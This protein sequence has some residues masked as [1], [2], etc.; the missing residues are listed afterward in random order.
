MSQTTTKIPLAAAA[1][2][3]EFILQ[4]LSEALEDGIV[5]GSIRRCRPEVGDIELVLLPTPD[6]PIVNLFGEEIEDS[7]ACTLLDR[8][9]GWLVQMEILRFE[10]GQG[11]RERRFT[12]G[13]AVGEYVPAGNITGARVTLYLADKLNYGN[14]VVLR[15]GCSAF[16]RAAIAVNVSQGG[17]L[18]D[19]MIHDGGYLRWARS[20]DLIVPCRTESEFLERIHV[21]WIDPAQRTEERTDELR[22]ALRVGAES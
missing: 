14:L 10:A 4:C 7:R 22:R 1:A 20:R 6:P 8:Q 16:S 15:T 19:G 11:D 3:A 13:P 12:A 18:P 21:P 2:A 17:L 5:A 9:I